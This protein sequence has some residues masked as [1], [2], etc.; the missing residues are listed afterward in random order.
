MITLAQNVKKKKGTIFNTT[1]AESKTVRHEPDERVFDSG[2]I[3]GDLLGA[4]GAAD[5]TMEAGDW[6][7]LLSNSPPSLSLSLVASGHKG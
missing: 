5:R 1:P 3:L 7:S 6:E 2:A 4:V